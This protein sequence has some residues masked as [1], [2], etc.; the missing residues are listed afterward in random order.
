MDKETL[1]F[2]LAA[3]GAL[4]STLLA[5][6]KAIETLYTVKHKLT[7]FAG[8]EPPFDALM[9]AVTNVGRR[10]VNITSL[11]LLYGPEPALA[12]PVSSRLVDLPKEKLQEGDL[13]TVSIPRE[14]LI[15]EARKNNVRQDY[16]HRLWVSVT[17]STG[18]SFHRVVNIDPSIIPTPFAT[19]AVYYIA[20]DL[21]LGFPQ[22]ETKPIKYGSR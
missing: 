14:E 3:W 20:S 18:K 6:P 12:Q 10:P 13:W 19:N 7:I 15:S 4:I 8:C 5:I 1:S 17:T 11:I 9:I 22:L 16:N 2:I 21:L